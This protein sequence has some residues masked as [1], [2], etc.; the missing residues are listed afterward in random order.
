MNLQSMQDASPARTPLPRISA[1]ALARREQPAL[2]LVAIGLLGLGVV[3]LIYGDFALVWQPVAAWIP[4]RTALAYLTGVLECA[5]AIGLLVPSTAPW[6]VRILLPGVIVW[7]LL[8]LP[9]LLVAPSVEGVYLGFGELAI[10]V[11]GSLSLFSRLARLQP[12]SVLRVL[13]GPGALGF[14]RL[15]FGLWII[16]IG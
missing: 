8:K 4:G 10:L 5:T 6:A 15:Y 7:Q 2:A 14:A 13:S 11:A 16:P 3:S 1:Q 12:G 9:A